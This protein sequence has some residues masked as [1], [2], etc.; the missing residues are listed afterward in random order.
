MG[1]LWAPES[2]A[3]PSPWR[4]TEGGHERRYLQNDPSDPA[5]IVDRTGWRVWAGP[6]RRTWDAHPIADRG[7]E[8]GAE[9]V[10]LADAALRR[11][12]EAAEAAGR[13]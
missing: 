8:T 10:A 5:A 11:I 3:A 1:I 4:P 13:G 6:R 7:P 2:P 12:F 9:G